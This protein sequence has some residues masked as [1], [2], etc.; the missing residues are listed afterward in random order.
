MAARL[1]RAVDAWPA[2]TTTERQVLALVSGGGDVTQ[3]D[4]V[5][6]TELSQQTV[7]RVAGDLVERGLLLHGERV[8]RGRRG[9][10]SAL[11]ALN[12]ER[13]FM[14]GVSI[15]ADAVSATLVDFE[16]RERGHVFAQP[17]PMS[18]AMVLE[19]VRA[20]FGRLCDEAAVDPARV[21][22]IGI[23]ITGY[24]LPG[25]R[26]FNPPPALDD[27]VGTDVAALFGEAFGRPAWADNDGNVAAVGESLVGV[28]R[29]ARN[30]AYLYIA[31]GFGGGLV[32]DG[33][34][35]RG[36]H[37]NAGEFAGLLPTQL[38]ASPTLGLLRHC[39]ARAG[40][41]HETI[42]DMLAAID[43]DA[44][45]VDDWLWR[46]GDTL[47][48]VCGA[49]AAIVDPEAIV[50]GGRLPRG[51]AERMITRID[52]RQ[53]PRWGV[54]RPQPKIVPAE[55]EGDATALG[56]AILPLKLNFFG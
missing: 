6:R 38:Y 48:L 33:Q 41:V 30:F 24:A 25:G 28:G 21:L 16:G 11:L 10:P 46:V 2:V 7:S 27:W 54:G 32:I 1:D 55:A 34:L 20:A 12:G 9:Q 26:T 53:T 52:M 37:G 17:Q 18:R 43:V 14:L 8:S 4:I 36:T 39:F 56:A 47:S 35:M 31:T 15:M 50:I 23:G 51:L 19:S 49:S 3:S 29:W 13:L 44:P 22:G 42:A 40:E 5:A 45:A